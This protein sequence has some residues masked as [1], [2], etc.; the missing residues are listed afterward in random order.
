[1]YTASDVYPDFQSEAAELAEELELATTQSAF[2]LP[3]A[4]LE[5]RYF[6]LFD[7]ICTEIRAIQA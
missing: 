3:S 4:E 5:Q 7:A 1:M 6:Q 2:V